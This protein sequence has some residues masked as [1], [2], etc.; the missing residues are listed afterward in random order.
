MKYRM[1]VD[2]VGNHDLKSSE[3]SNE[4][5][6]SLTG[7]IFD[8]DYIRT[9][10]HPE[11]EELKND[12]FLQHPDNPIILHRTEIRS[13]KPPFENLKKKE[14]REKFD[15][16]L[17]KLLSEWEYTVITVCLDKKIHKDTYITWQYHPYH[18]CLMLLLERYILFLKSNNNIG[19]VLAES[20]GG[21]EDRKLKDSYLRL[22]E[23]GTDFINES[24]FKEFLTSKQL[25][26]KPKINNIAGLQ[27]ADII[28][29]PSRND[30]LRVN[31][32]QFQ[33]IYPFSLKII[34]IL[35]DKYYQ[36]GGN[37]YGRKL[38]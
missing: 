5:F 10:V 13:A 29:H 33:K 8:L 3:D 28:A 2:E 22:W 6:L 12:I 30:I 19:D 26:V 38:Q 4:R 31:D 15:N 18:Y 25:K 37:I 7:V 24:L 9:N 23:H 1:Y 35:Q 34:E 16:R 32:L 11:L 27:V 20:R 36:K 14:T 21:K 17:L